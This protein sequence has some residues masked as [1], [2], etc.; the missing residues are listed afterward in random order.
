MTILPLSSL[1]RWGKASRERSAGG[2]AARHRAQRETVGDREGLERWSCSPLSRAP[3]RAA[4]RW[5]WVLGRVPTWPERCSG[6][7]STRL[8][9]LG[10]PR[11]R[12][13]KK[14]RTTGAACLL[15]VS[16]RCTALALLSDPVCKQKNRRPMPSRTEKGQQQNRRNPTQN[17]MIRSQILREIQLPTNLSPTNHLLGLTQTPGNLE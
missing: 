14:R 11:R 9:L 13:R 5:T 4:G 16:E 7:G 15:H 3:G 10:L 2:G 1:N 17:S 12:S 8:L 6:A